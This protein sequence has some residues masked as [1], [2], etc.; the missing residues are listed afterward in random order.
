MGWFKML[1]LKKLVVF[2][3]FGLWQD[4]CRAFGQGT[5]RVIAAVAAHI[6]TARLASSGRIQ[7]DDGYVHSIL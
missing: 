2:F 4:I 5:Q 1:D 7:D 3:S 6:Y